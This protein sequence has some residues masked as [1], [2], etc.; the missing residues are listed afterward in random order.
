MSQHVD[1]QEMRG[2][3]MKD[4]QTHTN[5]VGE[6]QG[7]DTWAALVR[8]NCEEAFNTSEDGAASFDDTQPKRAILIPLSVFPSNQIMKIANLLGQ[9]KDYKKFGADEETPS[10]AKEIRN[11]TQRTGTSLNLVISDVSSIMP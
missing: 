10:A 8:D 2:V 1:F 3:K 5:A 6:K 4:L 7:D 9:S 11:S